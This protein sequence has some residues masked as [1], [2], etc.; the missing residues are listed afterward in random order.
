[1]RLRA[2]QDA[3]KGIT[4]VYLILARLCRIYRFRETPNGSSKRI[5]R[6]AQGSPF[7]SFL[8]RGGVIELIGEREQTSAMQRASK[9]ATSRVSPDRILTN[10]I[11]RT[12]RKPETETPKGV[13]ATKTKSRSRD[14]ATIRHV[15]RHSQKH[16]S[17]DTVWSQPLAMPGSEGQLAQFCKRVPLSRK[18]PPSLP[19]TCLTT[20]PTTCD[21]PT[22]GRRC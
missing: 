15:G 18:H 5:I 16:T 7:C 9:N 1:M 11:Q 14:L 13:P 22:Q 21:R 2:L 6:K 10:P 4:F 19:S 17:T 8:A 3:S 20:T 12:T